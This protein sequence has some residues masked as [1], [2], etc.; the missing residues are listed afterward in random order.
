M[1][2]EHAMDSVGSWTGQA[3]VIIQFKAVSSK[4]MESQQAFVI[5]EAP[6]RSRRSDQ[7]RAE[8]ILLPPLI[9]AL[10]RCRCRCMF[11]FRS[12]SGSVSLS[13][14]RRERDMAATGAGYSYHRPPSR[15]GQIGAKTATGRPPA[16]LCRGR[17]PW[18]DHGRKVVAVACDLADEATHVEW[19]PAR[20]P[21]V[22]TGHSTG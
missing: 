10:V 11:R 15:S 7:S 5:S 17:G 14:Q 6:T 13:L 22:D 3:D 19:R 1:N 2:E 9:R 18:E 12:A 20:G 4:A 16:R 21:A 8:K